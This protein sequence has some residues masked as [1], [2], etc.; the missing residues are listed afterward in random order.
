MARIW[1]LLASIFLA[2]PAW[3]QD[4]F[5]AF[6]EARSPARFT[7]VA[8][9]LK[10]TFK[11]NVQLA[12]H[13]LEGDGGLR[14]DSVTDTR[15]LGTR[16]AFVRLDSSR[17]ALRLETPDGLSFYSELAFTADRARAEGAF[18]D[19]RQR[20]GA[21]SLHI[22]AGLH[23]PFV[24]I[25]DLTARAPLTSRVF[26]GSSEMHVIIE[27]SG[28]LGPLRWWAGLSA[29][30]MRPLSAAAI[31]DAA[32]RR[33]TLALLSYGEARP[34][35]GNAPVFGGK[36]AVGIPHFVLTGFGFLGRLTAVEGTDTLRNQIGHFSLLP[37]FNQAD[38]RDQ[39]TR[40]FWAGGR[41]D[42]NWAGAEARVEWI[43]SRESLL[44]RTTMYAQAG[45]VHWWNQ[46]KTAL[47]RTTEAR[48]RYERYRI[49][50]ADQPLTMDRALRAVD[51]SQ[52]VT[53]DWTVW[54]FALS[55]QIYRQIIRLNL[56][57]NIISEA[58]GSDALGLPDV[59]FANNET[60]L[61]LELR[62]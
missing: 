46:R 50:D 25:D 35:S 4:A 11:G 57:H 2:A 8:G 44:R 34:F 22:E 36:L 40:F 27:L 30:M 7:I 45:Y 28:G 12:L 3:A 20:L 58:N 49:H 16:S 37:N 18:L 5:D 31:N 29:A 59:A 62:F 54:T 19:Y 53:W 6:S 9:D 60:I 10:L 61:Q 13:D 41:A 15:T 56:E 47:F 42:F 23:T 33:G 43:E 14:K 24:A 38:P 48:V 17:L 39:D 32:S 51:P 21:G 55:S 26:W 1:L 52:A